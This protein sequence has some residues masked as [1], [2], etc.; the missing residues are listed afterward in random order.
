MRSKTIWAHKIYLDTLFAKGDIMNERMKKGE[1]LSVEPLSH[2]SRYLCVLVSGWLE[3]SVK[4]IYRQYI[5]KRASAELQRYALRKL[6]MRSAYMK[7][8]VSLTSEFSVEL[9]ELIQSETDGAIEA[10]VNTI[11]DNRHKIAHGGTCDISFVRLKAY[12]LEAIKAV[13]ILEKHCCN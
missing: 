10:A 7:N 8:I 9:S 3:V 1:V 12:Y 13:E 6:K 11:V 2:W 4:E 5:M